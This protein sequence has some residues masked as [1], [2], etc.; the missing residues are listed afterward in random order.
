MRGGVIL[1]VVGLIMAYLGVTGRYKCFTKAFDC[2]LG[3]DDG[4]GCGDGHT[5]E[6]VS[7]NSS[8]GG[9]PTITPLQPLKGLV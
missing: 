3:D 7:L 8:R 4:C 5:P 6:N 2:I 9:F 1:I